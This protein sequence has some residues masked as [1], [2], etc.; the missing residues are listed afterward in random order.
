MVRNMRRSS[1]YSDEPSESSKNEFLHFV[2]QLLHFGPDEAVATPSLSRFNEKRR[3]GILSP[4]L[5][6]TLSFSS[7]NSLSSYTNSLTNRA[8]LDLIF[9]RKQSASFPNARQ[10]GVFEIV[11]NGIPVAT[12]FLPRVTYKLGETIF[13]S[14]SLNAHKAQ[15]FNVRIA[16]ESSELLD[17]ELRVRSESSTYRT[18]RLVHA[19]ESKVTINTT[20][21]NFSLTLP[22]HS[23]PTFDTTK[24]KT[25]ILI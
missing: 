6:R 19:E 24:S 1:S 25:L 9:S 12:V 2:E 13:G 23:A 11:R 3:S 5:G 18:T 4:G 7:A 16:L 22:L 15:T 21:S 14:L 8:A 20:I 10:S 17:E